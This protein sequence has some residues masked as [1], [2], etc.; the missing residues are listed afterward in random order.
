MM[1]FAK[2]IFG[3]GYLSLCGWIAGLAAIL[4]PSVPLIGTTFLFILLDL[5]YGYKV[6]CKFSKDKHFQS[7]KLWD[8]LEKMCFAAL[9]ISGFTLLDKFV[10][11]TYDDLVLAKTIAGAT[12]FAEI[13]SL[14]ES[15]K[16]LKPNSIIT[17][18]FTK[19]IKSKAEKYLDVDITDIVD[20]DVK[21]ITNGTKDNTK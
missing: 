9:M 1:S 3:D 15:R 17:K 4:A 14:L 19:V 21:N 10:F 2:R 18:I 8:T 13:V 7:V 16:A 6:Y 12:C 11:M 20:E 5:Y